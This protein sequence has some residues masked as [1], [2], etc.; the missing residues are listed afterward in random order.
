MNIYCKRF[1]IFH[2][3]RSEVNEQRG[4]GIA[5]II[6]LGGGERNVYRIVTGK[7]LAKRSFERPRKR[8]DS[9]KTDLRDKSC[10]DGRLI[11]QVRNRVHWRIW[12][13][14]ISFIFLY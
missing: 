9:M 1:Q 5:N 4:A 14:I 10:E 7:P 8:K 12:N 11:G 13:N 2:P 3:N 6:F